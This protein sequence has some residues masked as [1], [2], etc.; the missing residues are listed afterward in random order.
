MKN[1]WLLLVLTTAL[2]I[3]T[4]GAVPAPQA[5]AAGTI[6]YYPAY[7]AKDAV[8][9]TTTTPPS[10]TSG[11][12]FAAY[13]TITG[14]PVNATCTGPKLRLMDAATSGSADSN[15]RTWA[16]A[17][18]GWL[19]D[20]GAWASFPSIT[21]NAS[22]EWSGWAYGAVPSTATN[23][24]LEARIRCG[25]NNY[26]TTSRPQIT[27]LTMTVAGDGGWLDESNGTARAGHAVVVK[28]G[29]TIVGM[30]V[31]EDNGVTEGYSAAPYYKVAVPAGSG[32][33]V[34]TWDLSTPGTA[35]GKV[36][37]MGAGSC[38]NTVTAGAVTSMNA[39]T[40]P[41]AIALRTLTAGAP[42]T[43]LATALPALGLAALGGLALSRRRRA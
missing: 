17:T 23:T 34:E 36:N 2:I 26:T 35:V 15:F 24:Y 18:S 32:Y 4:L 3:A 10:L 1:R 19:T 20:A 40:T 25:S 39:C 27:L 9:D 43:P 6:N 22:G 37:T 11:T 13:V 28:N 30:Y 41:T 31:A 29:A 5:L 12:P 7:V 16:G 14:A 8:F 42:L 33:T 21:T 38:P